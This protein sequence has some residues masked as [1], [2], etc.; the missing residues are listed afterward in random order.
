MT[1]NINVIYTHNDC[2]YYILLGSLSMTL[3]YGHRFVL[4][5]DEN[6]F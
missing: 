3:G 6:G 4:T 2:I 1:N 5:W